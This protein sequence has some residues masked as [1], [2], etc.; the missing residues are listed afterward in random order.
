MQMANTELVIM[1]GNPTSNSILKKHTSVNGNPTLTKNSDSVTL[2]VGFGNKLPNGIYK[3]VFDVY[4]ATSKAIKIFFFG[5]CGGVGFKASTKYS[6]WSNN[7]QGQEVQNDALG[8]YFTRGYGV[9]IHFSGE[10]RLFGDHLTNF[11]R[12]YAINN[13][14]AYNEIEKQK[15]EKISSEPDLLADNMTWIFENETN[16]ALGMTT[17]SYFYLERINTI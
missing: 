16:A 13:A 17:D 10:F 15:L 9:G 7:F 5:D 1:K 8:G 12:A 4:F 14:G 2:T 6:H 11:G 3:Y